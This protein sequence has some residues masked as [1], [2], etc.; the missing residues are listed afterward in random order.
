MGLAFTALAAA[1]NNQAPVIS[2]D[3][4]A[5]KYAGSRAHQQFHGGSAAHI[6]SAAQNSFAD[7]CAVNTAGVDNQCKEPVA[8]AY[9]HHDG[10]ISTKSPPPTPSSWTPNPCRTPPT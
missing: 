10:D 5:T 9:D 4:A 8:T 6:K 7:E 1:A 2:L 3:L